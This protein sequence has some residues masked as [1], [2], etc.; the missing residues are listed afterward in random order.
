MASALHEYQY[1]VQVRGRFDQLMSDGLNSED[2]DLLLQKIQ[3]RQKKD[4]KAAKE[5]PVKEESAPATKTS[6]NADASGREAGSQR[7]PQRKERWPTAGGIRRCCG[8]LLLMTAF[9][10]F[11]KFYRVFTLGTLMHGRIPNYSGVKPVLKKDGYG[12]GNWGTI[13]D[14]LEVTMAPEGALT[15]EPPF[16]E[17]EKAEES[18]EKSM[19]PV[20]EEQKTLTL[21]EYKELKKAS[22]PKVEL[23][24]TGG[25][26]DVFSDMVAVNQPRPVEQFIDVLAETEAPSEVS[27]I[28]TIRGRGGFDHERGR[29][30]LDHE[31][32]RG[33][34]DHDRG[35][36]GFDTE[37]GRGGRGGF[38]ERGRGGRG[39]PVRGG[40]RGRRSP[41]EHD[42]VPQPSAPM[43]PSMDSDVDF[44]SLK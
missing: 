41:L 4:Q 10:E 12:S 42:D 21:K 32:G 26:E 14:E 31:R 27:L 34:F 38:S 24:T 19:E 7:R 5:K 11:L 15:E 40:F 25:R 8:A 1:S 23:K 17:K 9:T 3:S 18:A 39:R 37:R 35:R 13:E 33:G 2:P 16:E 36:G 6:S 28:M 30:G 29:G 20:E 43:P 44:P 22:K